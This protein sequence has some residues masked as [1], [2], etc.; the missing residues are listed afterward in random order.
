[1]Q[2]SRRLTVV[3][4]WF[5]ICCLTIRR[6]SGS[7]RTDTLLP[8]TSRFRSIMTV[9]ADDDL[10]LNRTGDTEGEREESGE[11]QAQASH[12]ALL[13]S[14]NAA[15]EPPAGTLLLPVTPDLIRGP[16]FRTPLSGTPDQVGNYT[17]GIRKP[18]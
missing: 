3:C 15:C 8:D 6:P 9:K 2:F 11:Q 14:G 1:M 5:D 10:G 13:A 17:L 4:Y 18:P 12:A 16:A 7:T